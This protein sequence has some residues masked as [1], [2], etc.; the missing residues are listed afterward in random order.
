[1]QAVTGNVL[2]FSSG[3]FLRVFAT[4]WIRIEPV[5]GQALM[6]GTAS[7]SALSY[8]NSLSQ[9]AISFWNDTHHVV[10]T[11][12]QARVAPRKPSV[13]TQEITQ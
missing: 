11:N 6:L 9:P 1:V 10:T 13:A 2:L 3:H 7:L 5:N 4:R 8:E 12:G